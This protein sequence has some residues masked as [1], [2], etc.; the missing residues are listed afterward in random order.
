MHL[1]HALS[2]SVADM[3][4]TRLKSIQKQMDQIT[5][6]TLAL[7]AKSPTLAEAVKLLSG[8]KGVAKTALFPF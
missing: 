3:V 1:E 5:A 6:T 4:K 8:T 2:K 7:K